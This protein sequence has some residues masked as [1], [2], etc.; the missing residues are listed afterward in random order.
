MFGTPYG[1]ILL[2]SA[3]VLAFRHA[4]H[5]RASPR[6][7]QVVVGAFFVSTFIYLSYLDG[8]LYALA[9][10]LGICVYVVF[11]RL[12]EVEMDELDR[13][14][15]ESSERKKREARLGETDPHR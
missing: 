2:V 4:G 1:L 14:E 10:L 3:G 13:Q 15:R 11:C 9:P 7:K 12:I 8:P 6:S 5:D